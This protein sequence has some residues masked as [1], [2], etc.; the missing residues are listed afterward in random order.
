MS[1]LCCFGSD[2]DEDYITNDEGP[3]GE[4]VA[5]VTISKA[6]QSW[7]SN[8]IDDFNVQQPR[9]VDPI[10]QNQADI[11]ASQ[12]EYVSVTAYDSNGYEIG[13]FNIPPIDPNL[14][15]NSIITRL[16][17]QRYIHLL[18]VVRQMIDTM[19]YNERDRYPWQE[20]LDSFILQWSSGETKKYSYD[21]NKK[22]LAVS[23]CLP[24][25]NINMELPDMVT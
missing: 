12:P 22:T 15:N 21:S 10:A 4:I 6:I 14:I 7:Y 19:K 23:T 5:I 11:F 17:R 1:W 9:I 13:S 24:A 18:E 8:F 20:Y 2:E 16:R 3:A 25:R